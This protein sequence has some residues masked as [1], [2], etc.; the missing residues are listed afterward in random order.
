MSW[1]NVGSR[2]Q[3]ATCYANHVYDSSRQYRLECFRAMNGLLKPH[4]AW[5][6]GVY[7]AYM[8]VQIN[9]NFLFWI[10]ENLYL[11]TSQNVGKTRTLYQ[12]LL[13]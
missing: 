6:P 2:D 12:M 8:E 4:Q 13:I 3:G 5:V 7:P 9:N 11:G 10:E 1:V